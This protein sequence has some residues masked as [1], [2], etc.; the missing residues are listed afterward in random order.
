MN[1]EYN[2]LKKARGMARWLRKKVGRRRRSIRLSIASLGSGSSHSTT[3]RKLARKKA[4]ELAMRKLKK[5]IQNEFG[6]K[7]R[8]SSGVISE[9]SLAS[10]AR[11]ASSATGQDQEE[12]E[13]EYIE[14]Q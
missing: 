10:V 13:S 5:K 11:E 3:A 8:M 14:K 9:D 7:F 1:A 12:V 4:C 6:T 2:I